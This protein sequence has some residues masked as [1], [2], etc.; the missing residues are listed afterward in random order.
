MYQQCFP[1]LLLQTNLITLSQLLH[2]RKHGL[3]HLVPTT[4]QNVLL[5]P[6]FLFGVYH[7][8]PLP[9]GHITFV[10]ATP[11]KNNMSLLIEKLRRIIDYPTQAEVGTPSIPKATDDSTDDVCIRL[12]YPRGSRFDWCHLCYSYNGLHTD[13]F[14]CARHWIWIDL[15]CVQGIGFWLIWLLKWL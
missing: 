6:P 14:L 10:V 3:S 5:R 15:E 9:Q 7:T 2:L 11:K 4:I 8:L 1:Y 13:Y 12:Y